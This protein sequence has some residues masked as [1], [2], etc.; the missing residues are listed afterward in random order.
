MA[1]VIFKAN[2]FFQSCFGICFLLPLNKRWSNS[3]AQYIL[4]SRCIKRKSDEGSGI[5]DFISEMLEKHWHKNLEPVPM[6]LKKKKK[7]FEQLKNLNSISEIRVSKNLF[8]CTGDVDDETNK[9]ISNLAYSMEV[10]F[11]EII[12]CWHNAT[13]LCNYINSGNNSDSVKNLKCWSKLLS[14]YLVYLLLM[15]P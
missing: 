4:M 11:D 2:S 5:K 8:A 13:N 1:D 12:L 6:D 9:C 7:N 10:D 15:C 14:N 3:V